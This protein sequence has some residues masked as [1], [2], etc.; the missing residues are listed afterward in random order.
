[1]QPQ[2]RRQ[3]STVQG[4]EARQCSLAGDNYALLCWV[5][6]T[7]RGYHLLLEQI[8][9]G[10]L[11]PGQIVKLRPLAA[12]LS[13][14][15]YA[16]RRATDELY[17]DRLL[18]RVPR[19]GYRVPDFGRRELQDAF[20]ARG[21]LEL[22]VVRG[23][24]DRMGEDQLDALEGAI[25]QQIDATRSVTYYQFYQLVVVSTNPWRMPRANHR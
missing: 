24:I 23:A 5:R 2:K 10:I 16:V 15:L 1:M 4:E 9:K 14:S 17:Q 18:E 22:L 3:R 25:K 13:T 19:R 21:K 20:E 7:K 8:L 6:A 11:M 12:D